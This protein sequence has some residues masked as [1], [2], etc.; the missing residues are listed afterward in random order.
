MSY[1]NAQYFV[2]LIM[3]INAQPDN[4]RKYAKKFHKLLDSDAK[5]NYLILPIIYTQLNLFKQHAKIKE[6]ICKFFLRQ[7]ADLCVICF[8]EHYQSKI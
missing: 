7:F 4:R 3:I 8:V 5:K 2:I 1:V 6:K